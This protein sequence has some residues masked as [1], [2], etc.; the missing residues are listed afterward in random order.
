M[1]GQTDFPGICSKDHRH[2]TIRQNDTSRN[3]RNPAG[4]CERDRHSAE[5]VWTKKHKYDCPVEVPLDPS[6]TFTIHITK[7]NLVLWCYKTENHIYFHL[8]LL[9]FL[10]PKLKI[11]RLFCFCKNNSNKKNRMSFF[12]HSSTEGLLWIKGLLLFGI[13]SVSMAH[14]ISHV[15]ISLLLVVTQPYIKTQAISRETKIL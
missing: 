10:V 3:S 5:S 8:L 13:W 14:T 12:P 2:H 6:E 1:C 11:V 7:Y 9:F 15:C 4:H